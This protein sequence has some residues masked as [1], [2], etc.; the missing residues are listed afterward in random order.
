MNAKQLAD[1]LKPKQVWWPAR[2]LVPMVCL[3]LLVGLIA[4][5]AFGYR[6]WRAARAL[7]HELDAPAIEGQTA[8]PDAWLD[9]MFRQST[10]TAATAQWSE[11]FFLT[12]YGSWNK[13][14]AVELP[15]VGSAPLPRLFEPREPWPLNAQ[16]E[17][18]LQERRSLI[19]RI[20]QAAQLPTPVWQPLLLFDFATLLPA[21]DRVRYP[22]G[23]I[24]L[25]AEHAIYNAEAQRALAAI[26][27]MQAIAESIDWKP[28]VVAQVIA[29]RLRYSYLQT[30]QRSLHTALWNAEQL[31]TLMRQIDQPIAVRE[32]FQL[33][34]RGDKGVMTLLLDSDRAVFAGMRLLKSPNAKL[35]L[36]DRYDQAL[37]LA[38]QPGKRLSQL[39]ETMEHDRPRS[40]ESFLEA[41]L[42]PALSSYAALFEN[43]E[44]A[45][46]QTLVALAIK[47]FTIEHNR[48]PMTLAELSQVGLSEQD[49]TI[50]GV[51]SLGYE[52]DGSRAYVWGP[53][54]GKPAVA[55][56]RPAVDTEKLEEAL[57][58]TIVTFDAPPS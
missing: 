25:E 18:Y 48:L 12:S 52:V 53:Q 36:L 39:L 33:S 32:S 49:W 9:S 56:Q 3:P 43:A 41:C 17:E 4:V 8:T 55:P 24:Q 29:G 15:V 37:A 21:L 40:S 34:V 2:W 47:L 30:I 5:T 42:F 28:I 31:R 22:L 16:V 26:T 19:E 38:D 57:Q 13:K 45:R 7:P 14:D 23:L 1:K 11:I 54:H 6:E 46:Q 44:L 35:K 27:N 58:V 50:D 20:H 10:S 51:G